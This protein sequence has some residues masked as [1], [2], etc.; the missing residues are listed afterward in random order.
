MIKNSLFSVAVYKLDV[1]TSGSAAGIY[2]ASYQLGLVFGT[3][4]M[5]FIM[6][7]L[8]TK[9]Y[10]ENETIKGTTTILGRHALPEHLVGAFSQSM[11]QT[12][13]F[14]VGTLVVTILCSLFIEK[15]SRT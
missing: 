7:M 1:K 5:S 13:L 9:N 15:P 4:F 6:Q 12:L 2:N 11:A 8:L 3:S 14:V 10:P